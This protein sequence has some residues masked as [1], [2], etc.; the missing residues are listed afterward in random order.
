MQIVVALVSGTLL[1]YRRN[2]INIYHMNKIDDEMRSLSQ[3]LK[4]SLS[5]EITHSLEEALQ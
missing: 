4:S 1:R 2:A 3:I 5:I